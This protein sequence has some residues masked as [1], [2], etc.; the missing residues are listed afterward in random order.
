M[1]RLFSDRCWILKTG[2]ALLLFALC[3]H[4][5][6]RLLGRLHAEPELAATHPDRVLG[7]TCHLWAK[8]VLRSDASGFELPSKAGP[9]RIEGA[10]AETGS[11]V[12]VVGTVTGPRLVRAERIHVNEG[13]AWKRPLNYGLS[14]LTVLA[15][16]ASLRKRF[17]W[18]APDGVVSGRY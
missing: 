6:Q 8:R 15:V 18:R 12:S 1:K 3:C 13:Y 11:I 10:R 14:I 5:S 4:Q 16:L 9:I 7:M 2:G 17:R